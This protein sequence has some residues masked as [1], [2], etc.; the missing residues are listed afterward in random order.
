[1]AELAP[2]SPPAFGRV[3]KQC[4]AKDPEDRIQTAHD[5][6]LQLEWISESGSQAGAAP[7]MVG[8]KSREKIAWLLAGV[9]AIAAISAAVVAW[10]GG[11]A[12]S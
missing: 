5:V 9:M 1:M 12:V 3:V 10:R 11:G 6:R 4:L 8:R 2:M 7:V